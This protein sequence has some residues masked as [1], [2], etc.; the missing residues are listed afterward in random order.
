MKGWDRLLTIVVLAGFALIPAIFDLSVIHYVAGVV[1]VIAILIAL[2]FFIMKT[3]TLYEIQ[4]G[5]S[6]REYSHIK[7]NTRTYLRL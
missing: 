5:H 2:A 4:K 6:R 3:C 7:Y 1:S